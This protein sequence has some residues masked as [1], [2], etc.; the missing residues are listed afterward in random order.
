[1][2]DKFG[3]VRQNTPPSI[4]VSCIQMFINAI[5]LNISKKL[6]STTSNV[7]EV[8]I[9]KTYNKIYPYRKFLFLFYLEK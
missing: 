1:M 7:S 8:T 4:A 6:L 9:S 2:A 5:G 3:I